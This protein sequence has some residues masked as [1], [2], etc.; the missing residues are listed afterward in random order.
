MST[1]STIHDSIDEAATTVG[2]LWPI[3]SFVTANPLSGFEDQPFDEAVE[4]A[5]DLLGGR[6]YP[7]AETFEF[8]LERGQIDPEILE[9]ELAEVGYDDDP[10][11]L[12]DRMEAAADTGESKAE[13]PTDHVDHVLTKWLSAFLDQGSAHWS[14]PNR[15]AGFYAAFRDVADYDSEIPDEG[16]VAELPESPAEAIETV[17]EPYSE[18][19][20]EAIFEEQLAALPGW[21]G[22]IKQRTDDDGE[23][24]STYPISL[25]GYLAARLALLD[26]V[27]VDIDA[28]PLVNAVAP[29]ISEVVPLLVEEEAIERLL[30][31]VD[32]RRF[33]PPKLLI[34]VI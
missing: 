8:A 24:Q 20:W 22:F 21:T 5:A 15:E 10:E 12:L 27:G 13:T 9:A 30:G 1:E 34:Q 6:G 7:S 19:Q 16:V 17:V 2:S 18:S 25:E 29:H 28:E 33:T 14:M 31:R 4:Q 23:W 26:A 32:V 3:H 11:A